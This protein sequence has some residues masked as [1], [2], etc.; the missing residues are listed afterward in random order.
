MRGARV[1]GKNGEGLVGDIGREYSGRK[2]TSI[3]KENWRNSQEI[4]GEKQ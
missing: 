4:D 3:D 2:N 1:F